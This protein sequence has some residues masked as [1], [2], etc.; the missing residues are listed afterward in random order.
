MVGGNP[1]GISR[2]ER[3]LGLESWCVAFTQNKWQFGSDEMLLADAPGL[4]KGELRRWGLVFRAL[5]KYD[6]IHYNFGS[7]II[8]PLVPRRLRGSSRYPAPLRAA[9][10][11]YRTLFG[12]KD[13]ALLK[14]AS[15]VI[16][17]T[18]QGGDGRIF[19]YHQQH[20][21][22][23]DT[24]DLDQSTLGPQAFLTRAD[25]DD[26][27]R[28]RIR[29]F[30]NYADRIFALNP[31]LLHTLPVRAK[32]LPYASVDPREWAPQHGA[33]SSGPLRILH[34]PSGR[35]FKGTKYL[36]EAAQ[37]L[38][39][40]GFQFELQLVEGVPHDEVKGLY[41]KADL[42]VDQLLGGWYGALAVE[43]MALGKP[44]IAY[45]RE[46]DLKFI[47]P[48]MKSDLPIIN[49]TPY[50]IYDVLKRCLQM[51]RADLRALGARSRTYVERWHDPIK[52]ATQLKGEA[53]AVLAA[54]KKGRHSLAPKDSEEA[55]S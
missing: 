6:V 1:Q 16:F 13:V 4:T 22:I 39:D 11:L 49:A 52:I 46:E 20:Y 37:R 43:L 32:F 47:P 33:D 8:D 29:Y 41:H 27:K 15:K 44:A 34:A 10:D 9:Y 36:L 38:Q 24:M 19:S 18:Y 23:Y 53:E 28:Q 26:W 51:D 25:M 50:D 3:Q 17:V 7:P 48:Q 35:I 21:A 5:R 55:A 45:I 42:L 2:A 54:R 30:D 31:D 40:D 12:M 14:R